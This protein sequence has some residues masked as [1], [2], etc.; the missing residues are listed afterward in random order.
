MAQP[1][2]AACAQERHVTVMFMD[3][4][5]FSK[6]ASEHTA[7]E[8]AAHLNSVFEVIG[9]IIERAGGVIDKYTGD[10]LMAFWGAPDIQLNHQRRALIAALE[11][12]RVLS[13]ADPV[14]KLA[15]G[16]RLR[17][18]LHSGSAIVG[19]LGFGGTFQLHTDWH[20]GEY[21]RT[22]GTAFA[23]AASESGSDYWFVGEHV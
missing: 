11:I 18:G 5:G 13:N 12:Q 1:Q 21:C 7:A 17:I 16:P 3:M 2:D 20:D 8:T 19:N 23:G 10:G 6:F 9:P 14:R 15:S 4:E 22:C